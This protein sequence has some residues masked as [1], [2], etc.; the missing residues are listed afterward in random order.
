M[1][2]SSQVPTGRVRIHGAD[3]LD[4]ARADALGL[5]GLAGSRAPP[6]R[7]HRA[8]TPEQR[9]V[10]AL[11][12]TTERMGGRAHVRASQ[13]FE[14]IEDPLLN[15]A[16]PVL[17]SIVI[18]IVKMPI[19]M[20]LTEVINF[21]LMLLLA[22]PLALA[23]YPGT[24]PST[25]PGAEGVPGMKPSSALAQSVSSTTTTTTTTTTTVEEE[26]VEEFIQLQALAESDVAARPWVRPAEH[27]TQGAGA[28]HGS[29]GGAAML[30]WGAGSQLPAPEV[31]GWSREDEDQDEDEDEDAVG[32]DGGPS[33]GLVRPVRARR[34]PLPAGAALGSAGTGAGGRGGPAA[35]GLPAGVDAGVVV[36]VL[37]LA[38]KLRVD[39]AAL[40]QVTGRHLDK[41]RVLGQ[42]ERWGAGGA[43]GGASGAGPTSKVEAR[44]VAA[45]ADKAAALLE[46]AMRARQMR[47][48]GHGG[49]A[50]VP[51]EGR[52]GSLLQAAASASAPTSSTGGVPGDEAKGGGAGAPGA[53]V[54]P[55]AW[56]E[57][58]TAGVAEVARWWRGRA[59]RWAARGGG[60][61]GGGGLASLLQT[62]AWASG[63]AASRAEA[64]VSAAAE[65]GLG[66]RGRFG[67]CEARR[68][69]ASCGHAPLSDGSTCSWC[70][71]ELDGGTVTGRC[72][73]CRGAA[74]TTLPDTHEP[75]NV[76]YGSSSTQLAEEGWTCN[77]RPSVCDAN[78]EASLAK[79]A[80]DAR[81]KAA[82][83][84]SEVYATA[85]RDD[86][87]PAG[88]NPPTP[89]APA[90]ELAQIA[91][92]ATSE[93]V[94]AALIPPLHALT[95]GM[96]ASSAHTAV[97]RETAGRV[98][99]SLALEMGGTLVAKDLAP[100]LHRGVV[101]GLAATLTR[102]L[103]TDVAGTVAPALALSLTRDPTSDHY[104]FLCSQQQVYCGLC[105]KAQQESAATFRRGWL[106]GRF[107]GNQFGLDA[108][109]AVETLSAEQMSR[110]RFAMEAEAAED[111]E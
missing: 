38:R 56:T 53:R 37:R 66:E 57:E 15:L 69:A 65:A 97:A 90:N 43:A 14:L 30:Q 82:K 103:A 84:G 1:A 28:A 72:V 2:D 32:D 98:V 77:P 7:G 49:A 12:E 99:R 20:L 24:D 42:G 76:R 60:G 36:S 102:A 96:L 89:E 52:F 110:L 50:V 19:I 106:Y 27:G 80:K 74:D 39:R 59:E 45:L 107:Y 87:F 83:A 31:S 18:S 33:D 100:R 35:T 70:V 23:I 47:H 8:V 78:N 46:G 101:T 4:P 104:C 73:M 81:A 79:A 92:D 111:T 75:G 95:H 91:S 21:F 54:G 11:L 94:G 64:A 40:L 10:L 105:K 13:Y 29:G 55:E 17:I 108:M 68:D 62:Q 26:Y 85:L 88:A 48:G 109:E 25:I 61:E 9:T 34:A 93:A 58:D 67:G 86:E 63:A 51:L 16:V 71:R 41:M 3:D 5:L 22:I 44:H 6:S